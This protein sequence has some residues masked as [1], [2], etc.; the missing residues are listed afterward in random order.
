MGTE[1]LEGIRASFA[2]VGLPIDDLSDEQIETGL[3]G[4]QD[5]IRNS[6]FSGAQAAKALASLAH[7]ANPNGEASETSAG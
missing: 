1:G 4:M 7:L 2:A 6:G 5:A 3:L